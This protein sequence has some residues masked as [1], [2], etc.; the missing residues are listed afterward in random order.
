M[1]AGTGEEKMSFAVDIGA[2]SPALVKV[3]AGLVLNGRSGERPP[4]DEPVDLT[5]LAGGLEG[6]KISAPGEALSPA[7]AGLCVASGIA[8]GEVDKLW[9]V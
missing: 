9:L 8:K 4:S 1:S 7:V 5:L 3:K 2:V 6:S